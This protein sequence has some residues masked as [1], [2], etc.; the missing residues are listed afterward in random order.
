MKSPRI[1]LVDDDADIRETMVT[2]LSMNDYQ[3][4]AVADGQSAIDKINREKYNIVITDLMM[5]KMSGIEVIKNLKGIDPDL[6]CIVITGYATV[7]TAVDAMKAG[8]YDYLMKPFNGS[9]VLMLLK[10]VMELQDLQAENSQLKRNLQ[11]RYDYENLIGSS[12]GIQK[13]C[14]LIEKV[15]ET[16]STILILGESGTGK[17][18]V[19]RTIHYNSP[20]KNKPLIPINC[21]AIP[22]TLLESE[23]FGHEKGAF[24]GAS[25]TRIGR[26]ELADGGTLFLD[27][28]GDMSPTLQVK[29]LRVLQQREFE[30]VGGVKTIKVDVRIIAATNIDL[31][32]AVNEGKFREDLYYRLN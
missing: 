28:I 32:H 7:S 14:S 8:A 21:G 16:D 20:R 10:R 31:E 9:E 26:F 17:E 22:E 25:A 12:E 29:L 30:R 19:A 1:L 2:L 3:V 5:P 6:Q 13:V 4:T 24:T 11:H 27:E 15:A 18:L 23:L